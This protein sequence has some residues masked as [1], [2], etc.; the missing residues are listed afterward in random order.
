MAE[1]TL[2]PGSFLS[3]ND[4]SFVT[5]G[6][7]TVGAAIVG[8]TVKGKVGI[9]T[10]VT[11]YSD[12]LNKFGST[13]TSG[14]AVYT[15][16][17]SI[18]AY[19]YFTNG[20][21]SLL[22]TRVA[23]GSFTPAVSSPISA[24]ASITAFTLETLSVG[25]IMNNSGSEDTNGAL[26]SGSTD[27]VRWEINQADTSSGQFT[28]LVRQGNDKTVQKSVLETWSNLSLDPLASNYIEKVIG[29]QIENIRTDGSTYYVQNSGSFPNQSRYIRVKSVALPTPNYFDNN[30][31]AKSQ[32]TSSIPLLA[33]GTFMSATGDVPSTIKFYESISNTNTQGLL[34]NDYTQSLSLLNN[35]DQYKYTTLVAPGLVYNFAG[36]VSPLNT[37]MNNAR[38]RADFMTVVDLVEYASNTITVTSKAALIDNS[39]VASYWPWLQTVDPNTGAYVWVPASTMIPGVFAKSDSLSEPWFAAAG[40]TRGGLTN[41]I[42]AEQNLPQTTRDVLYLGKVNPI[43]TFPGQG[44]VVWG[45][46]TLQTKASALDRV[47]VRRLL[48]TLKSF[49][50]QVSNNLVF[51]Q[52]EIATRN[53]FLSQVNPYLESVKQRKGLYAYR[54]VMDESNN[55]GDTI[56]RLQLVGKI[57]LQPTKTAEFILL[58]FNIL[59]TGATFPS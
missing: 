41:V 38:N 31:I 21:E 52:N 9:P 39:Y 32:Y 27:N 47:N 6:P 50:S 19:N 28:L 34:A 36:H 43:A 14:G 8:P 48:L 45:Q 56:D 15:Y 58:D 12:Y 23:S 55:T 59:P 42:Q 5:Q 40:F 13:I 10:L 1:Q 44:V 37:L 17:T 7:V 18:A 33:S 22:V 16:F 26:A 4:Q 20:G 30:G 51:D 54:V 25:V 11:S 24:S 3:E 29:N 46:K 35:K 53:S 57:Y 49:I 2:S